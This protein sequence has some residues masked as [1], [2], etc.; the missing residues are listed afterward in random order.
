MSE[1]I[2]DSR[3]KKPPERKAP[4]RADD[5]RRS[6]DERHRDDGSQRVQVKASRR[7]RRRAGLAAGF[8]EI[9]GTHAHITANWT[10]TIVQSVQLAELLLHLGDASQGRNRAAGR[11]SSGDRKNTMTI[12]PMSE[13]RLCE[14]TL[15][16]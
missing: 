2:D 7:H 15:A 4:Q 11:R 13:I 14:R 1:T 12:R 5:N 9:A 10:R 16:A 3:S 6:R 8:A